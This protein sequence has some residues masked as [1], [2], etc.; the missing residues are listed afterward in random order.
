LSEYLKHVFHH[1]ATRLRDTN[2]SHASL[3]LGQKK[4]DLIL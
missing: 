1:G 3:G 2:H 4:H